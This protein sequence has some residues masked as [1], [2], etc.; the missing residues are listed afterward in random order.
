MQHQANLALYSY[1]EI[2]N[3]DLDQVF[4]LDQVLVSDGRLITLRDLP[5]YSLV[6]LIPPSGQ[7]S[8]LD[9][10]LTEVVYKSDLRDEQEI[11]FSITRED[12]LTIE[13]IPAENIAP[14]NGHLCKTIPKLGHTIES[15]SELIDLINKLDRKINAI[16]LSYP[17]S[18]FGIVTTK[19]VFEGQE[20]ILPNFEAFSSYLQAITEDNLMAESNTQVERLVKAISKYQIIRELPTK[21]N[22]SEIDDQDFRK[23]VIKL[24]QD[25]WQEFM[26]SD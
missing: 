21:L 8:Y 24:E 10:N 22:S 20:L 9:N 3:L 25:Y 13:S 12:G 19:E 6:A 1:R 14:W 15:I 4:D 23:L 7:I 2:L 18:I 11:K 5:E 16:Y 17:G 26:K